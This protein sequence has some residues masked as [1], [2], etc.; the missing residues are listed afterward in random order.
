[1]KMFEEFVRLAYSPESVLVTEV[2]E[3]Y[4]EF[5]SPLYSENNW[6]WVTVFTL[7]DH[8]ED[9]VVTTEEP[10][11]GVGQLILY[12]DIWNFYNKYRSY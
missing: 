3:Q 5:K 4:N 2:S 8:S 7:P 1:M 11:W 10:E 12:Q 6:E 9:F